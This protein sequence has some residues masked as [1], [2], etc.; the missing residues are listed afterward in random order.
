MAMESPFTSVSSPGTKYILLNEFKMPMD[1]H[2]RHLYIFRV[3]T[4]FIIINR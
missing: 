4:W 2:L 3:R 1:L